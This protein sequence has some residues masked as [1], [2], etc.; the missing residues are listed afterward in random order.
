MIGLVVLRQALKS[1]EERLSIAAIF[2]RATVE[3]DP[4]FTKGQLV[5]C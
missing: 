3:E 1:T 4:R 2:S 5:S